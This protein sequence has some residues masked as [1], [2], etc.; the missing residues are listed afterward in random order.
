MKKAAVTEFGVN[1]DSIVT[2]R[3]WLPDKGEWV[4]SQDADQKSVEE[5]SGS[6]RNICTVYVGLR[7]SLSSWLHP[8]ILPYSGSCSSSNSM[9]IG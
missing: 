9:H 4:G 6:Y 2:F 5:V 1:R 3:L 8:N 7:L